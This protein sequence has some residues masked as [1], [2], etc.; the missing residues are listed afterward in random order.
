MSAW[1]MSSSAATKGT[2]NA[3]QKRRVNAA[4][5]AELLFRT[6]KEVPKRLIRDG[7]PGFFY[8]DRMTGV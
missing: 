8:T 5:M 6:V 7:N 3:A 1:S 2:A 4:F